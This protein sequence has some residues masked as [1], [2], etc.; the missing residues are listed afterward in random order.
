MEMILPFLGGY[1]YGDENG[2]YYSLV[3]CCPTTFTTT[4]PPMQRTQE[5]ACGL[6]TWALQFQHRLPH[7]QDLLPR[8]QCPHL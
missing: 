3:C 8:I 7:S 2:H 1:F 4:S 5:P 6:E